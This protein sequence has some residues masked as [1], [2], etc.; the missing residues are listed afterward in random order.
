MGKPHFNILL[1]CCEACVTKALRLMLTFTY[2]DKANLRF[3]ERPSFDEF[4][5]EACAGDFDAVIIYGNCLSQPFICEGGILENTTLAI[6]IIKATRPVPILAMN[7]MPGYSEFL[8]YAGADICLETPCDY[9]A[10]KDFMS[11]ALR[12]ALERAHASAPAHRSGRGN[13]A[14]RRNSF[15]AIRSRNC[16]RRW[17]GRGGSSSP[18]GTGSVG[19]R[20]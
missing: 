19:L 14:Q 13:R 1:G 11:S 18:S 8:R 7:S 5:T 9:G 4:V 12:H 10:I 2:R 20:P 17:R 3:T 6:E 16:P 15:S